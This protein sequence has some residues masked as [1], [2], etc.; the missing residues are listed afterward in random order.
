[1]TTRSIYANQKDK[2]EERGHRGQGA[3]QKFCV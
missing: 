3:C 2:V 1:M